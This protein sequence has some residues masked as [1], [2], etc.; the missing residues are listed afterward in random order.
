MDF[1]TNGKL[2]VIINVYRAFD[3]VLVRFTMQRHNG[4]MSKTKDWPPPTKPDGFEFSLHR[5]GW[6]KWYRG[7]TRTIS[8]KSVDRGAVRSAWDIKRAEIDR[9]LAEAAPRKAGG[10]RLEEAAAHYFDFLDHRVKTEKPEP[11]SQFT[12]VLYKRTIND[13]GSFVGAIKLLAEIDQEDFSTYARTFAENSPTT[14][15]RVVSAIHAFFSYCVDEGLLRIAPKYG[16]YFVKPS[17]QTRR[18][19]RYSVKKSFTPDEIRALFDATDRPEEKA[20]IVAGACGALDNAD[21]GNLT[22]EVMDRDQGV[23]DYRRKKTGT[24]RRVIP[25]PALFWELLELYARPNPADPKYA[26][27]IFLTPTGL[28]LQRLIPSK[29]GVENT[30]DYVAMRFVRIMIAAKLRQ[31]MPRRRDKQYRNLPPCEK[32]KGV[33][34]GKGFRSL[35]TTFPNLAKPGFR[36]EIEIVMGHSQGT[37]LLE[38]YLEQVSMSRLRELVD[39]IYVTVFAWPLRQGSEV[40]RL[41]A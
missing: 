29:T 34:N 40:E 30:I 11:L 5:D 23:L 1:Q 16:R 41:V 22:E 28:P 33:P 2:V 31:P 7:Q 6:A 36:D 8:V 4:S 15:Y 35:R 32:V 13:F 24:I 17:M 19:V 25:M 26:K 14:L 38:N 27:Y 18:D 39:H 21:I 9:M 10:W 37:I 20:W 3:Y 12:A